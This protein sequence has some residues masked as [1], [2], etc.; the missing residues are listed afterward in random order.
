MPHIWAVANGMRGP[1]LHRTRAVS[2]TWPDTQPAVC[3]SRALSR[4]L[5]VVAR[6]MHLWPPSPIPPLPLAASPS[7]RRRRLLSRLGAAPV[8]SAYPPTS[9]IAVGPPAA[10]S[11]G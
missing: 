1:P 8:A 11:T 3:L 5:T 4:Q 7:V 10:I 9:A 2:P 6:L